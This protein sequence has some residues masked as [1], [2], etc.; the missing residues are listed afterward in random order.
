MSSKF[1]NKGFLNDIIKYRSSYIL[2]APF[3]IV[4]AL[5]TVWPVIMSLGISFTNFNAF[6]SPQFVG[7]ENYVKLFFQDDIFQIAL[8]NTILFAIITGPVGYLLC[9]FFAW[10]VNE[11]EGK[12]RAFM[13]FVLYA[14]TMVGNV[15]VIWLIV[16][17]GDIYGYLNSFLT[18]FGF[19]REP[20]QWLS[21][22]SYMMGVVIVVQLW[23]SLGTSFLT[24]RAGFTTIDR[25]Y[26]E[27]AAIDGMK[28]RWQELWYI[29]L[30]M[31]AP[32]LMLSAVL[33][34]TSAFA[35]VTVATSLTGFP[36]TNYATHLV[37]HHLQDYALTRHERGY[38][39]AIATVLF[40]L[41]FVCNKLAQKF[42]GRVGKS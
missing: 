18:Y 3:L 8:Q 14:P 22:P 33:S 40:L 39:A 29:T 17:D 13:T 27:A 32:H 26:Y 34:I 12:L 4:F 9:L 41:S 28:N 23:M 38:A 16:F 21:D 31:M 5:F 20:I 11:L 7:M 25:Q 42:L 24:L 10:V 1:K 19:I 37:M 15:F 36:S 30:P 2:M 35:S 6:E